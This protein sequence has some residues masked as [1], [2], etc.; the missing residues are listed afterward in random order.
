MLPDALLPTLKAAIN[1][2]TDPTFVGYRTSGSTGL[3]ADWYKGASTFIVWRSTTPTNDIGAAITWAN[4]TP[5][6]APD[7]TQIWTN[8]ALACQGKQF[9][10]QNL[11]LAAAGSAATGLPNIRAGLT[12]LLQNI[13][14]GTGGALLGAGWSN[15]KSA[16][17]RAANR[18]EKVFATGT[19]TSGSPGDLGWEGEISD[20]DVVRALAV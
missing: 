15:V 3:M 8:R 7:S 9:N 16:I 1:A 18:G 20:S 6:D 11:L 2:E 5:S 4:F 13:P 10:L 17:S 19:G 14:A 12:D